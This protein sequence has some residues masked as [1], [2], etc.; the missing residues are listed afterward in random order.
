MYSKSNRIGSSSIISNLQ[1]IRKS[2]ARHKDRTAIFGCKY[3]PITRA[4]TNNL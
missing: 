1:Y 2:I 3:A 4:I